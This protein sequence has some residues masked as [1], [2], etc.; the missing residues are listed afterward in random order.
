MNKFFFI[1]LEKLKKDKDYFNLA[2]IL[3]V[4]LYGVPIM[5]L[6]RY[7]FDFNNS[8]IWDGVYV[9]LVLTIFLIYLLYVRYKYFKRNK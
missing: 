5:D 9:I 3:N 8:N 7:K 6:A 2:L 4:T 1:N